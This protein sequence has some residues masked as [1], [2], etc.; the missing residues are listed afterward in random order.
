LGDELRF[1]LI[2]SA[3]TVEPEASASAEAV[4]TEV[5]GLKVLV[6]PSESEK[7]VRCWHHRPDVGS[8]ATHPELCQRCVSNIDGDGEERLYA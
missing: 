8:N 2:V 4:E 7:C 6:S 5:E 1:V 3:A